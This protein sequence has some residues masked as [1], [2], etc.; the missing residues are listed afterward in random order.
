MACTFGR[1][2]LDSADLAGSA[3][4]L[5]DRADIQAMSTF[6]IDS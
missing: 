5:I 3:F 6:L 1:R 4:G 2:S